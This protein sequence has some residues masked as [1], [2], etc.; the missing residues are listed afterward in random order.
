MQRP[1]RHLMITAFMLLAV[2]KVMLDAHAHYFFLDLVPEHFHRL[3]DS[4]NGEF[5]FFA[6]FG[7]L[8]I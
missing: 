6:A 5:G 1:V 7:W 3:R 4:R 8:F 2:P